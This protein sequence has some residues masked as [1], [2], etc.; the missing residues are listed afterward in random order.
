[1]FFRLVPLPGPPVNGALRESWC[2]R[3]RP[4][5]QSPDVARTRPNNQKERAVPSAPLCISSGTHS[6]F[7][8]LSSKGLIAKRLTVACAIHDRAFAFAAPQN[9]RTVCYRSPAS[10]AWAQGTTL[11]WRR[12]APGVSP[13]HSSKAR[14]KLFSLRKPTACAICL[15]GRTLRRRSSWACSRRQ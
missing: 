2:R 12:Y 15:I 8:R 5:Y 13:V 14:A 7:P 11:P 4:C 3:E 9:A 10:R 6:E 1:M